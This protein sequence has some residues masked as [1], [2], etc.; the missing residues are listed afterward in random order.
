MARAR[1]HRERGFGLL[2]VS[3]VILIMATVAISVIP[4]LRSLDGTRARSAASEVERR[5]VA[6]RAF[7]IATGRPAGLQ[8]ASSE[9]NLLQIASGETEP[10]AMTDALGQADAGVL[11]TESYAGVSVP[12]VLIGGVSGDG[13]VWFSHEGEPELRDTDGVLTG[14]ATDESRFTLD[15]FGVSWDV[16]VEPGSGAIWIEETP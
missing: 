3:L 10:S 14:S 6:A 2:E 5:L 8:V 11:I 4:A 15:G 7:A 1:R 16:V 13:V 12:A 9:F